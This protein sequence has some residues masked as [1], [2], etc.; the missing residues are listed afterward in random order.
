[1]RS[2]LLLFLALANIC[3]AQNSQP[4]KL[5]EKCAKRRQLNRAFPKG[6]YKFR[7]GEK[8]KDTPL[9]KFEISE[10]GTVT[11]VRLVRSSG[12]KDIDEKILAAVS[13][14][15]WESMPGCGVIDSEMTVVIDFR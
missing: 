2:L 7:R 8:Y 15:K 12:V 13:K 5:P 6:P 9:F 10:Q 1:M 4:T 11:N 14:W 3:S